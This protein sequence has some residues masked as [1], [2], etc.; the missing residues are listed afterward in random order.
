MRMQVLLMM[1]FLSLP[2]LASKFSPEEILGTYQSTDR[3]A[4]VKIYKK[5]LTN[6]TLFEP[7][8]FQYLVDVSFDG[9]SC[10]LMYGGEERQLEI[11]QLPLDYNGT[12]KPVEYLMTGYAGRSDYNGSV[13][14]E[15]MNFVAKKETQRNRSS[16]I[17]FTLEFSIGHNPDYS[18]G[19]GGGVRAFNRCYKKTK[20]SWQEFKKLN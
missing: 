3:K 9:G 1:I 14:L 17:S 16:T 11:T 10:L 6:A 13:Y 2:A 15:D 7:A 20:T 8:K 12:W 5:M 18:D 4:Q 19:E